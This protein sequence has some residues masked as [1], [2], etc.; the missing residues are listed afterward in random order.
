MLTA[1]GGGTWDCQLKVPSSMLQGDK[2]R[3]RSCQGRLAAR[4]GG[5]RA[6]SLV[7][8][9]CPPRLL[10]LTP[11]LVLLVA[12]PLV[13]GQAAAGLLLGGGWRQAGGP[14]ASVG[15]QWLAGAG[16]A[17][18]HFCLVEGILAVGEGQGRWGPLPSSLMVCR[19]ATQ[20]M[21]V[22]GATGDAKLAQ[23][24]VTGCGLQ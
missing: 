14:P 20:V 8:L 17:G 7:T 3:S 13:A 9:L 23:R 2:C 15:G 18:A 4:E 22:S 11:C 19:L 16:I 24:Q 10:L 21:A 6:S 5:A 1:A 12:G